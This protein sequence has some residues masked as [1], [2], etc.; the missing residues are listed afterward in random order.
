VLGTERAS[1]KYSANQK[2]ACLKAK[3]LKDI[4]L[5][6]LIELLKGSRRS[7]R[8]LSKLLGVSQPTVSRVRSKLEKEG[9]IK[10]YTIIPDFAS[11]GFQLMSVTFLKLKKALSEEG[12]ESMR[13]ISEKLK[14]N[15]P[16][17][18][19]LAMSGIGMN[20][21]RVVVTY[22]KNYSE[23]VDFVK[24]SKSERM[25]VAVV[26]ETASFLVDL[27]DKTNFMPLTLSY[28]AYYLQKT[29]GDSERKKLPSA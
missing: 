26:G 17:A 1:V 14:E 29:N 11:F 5:R 12:V 4:E 10:E 8:E 13:T 22:H 7:D 15:Y 9:I 25:P 19:I 16:S 2:P 24:N 23:Y 21:D 6:L 28:L 3:L 27:N 18:T 20:Y